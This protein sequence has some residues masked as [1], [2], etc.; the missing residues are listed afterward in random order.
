MLRVLDVIKF[1][2]KYIKFCS[3]LYDILNYFG[4]SIV[5]VMCYFIYLWKL[6][7]YIIDNKNEN[8][9]WNLYTIMHKN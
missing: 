5:V 7:K 9:D 8:G 2:K 4:F 1:I 6:Y 3:K